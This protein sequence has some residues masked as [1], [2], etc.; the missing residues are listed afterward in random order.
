MIVKNEASN[1]I[2]VLESV[3]RH[4]SGV[5]VCDTGSQDQ[6][7][8][9]VDTFC[10]SHKAIKCRT[11]HHA[12]EDFAH[13]RNLCFQD[14][15][16][17]MS[18]H[19][20]F[21]LVLDADQ[22]LIALNNQSLLEL[23][24]TADAYKLREVSHGYEYSHFRLT[25]VSKNFQYT[26]A[27]HEVLTVKEGST[28]GDLPASFYT[29]HETH[30]RRGIEQ[31]II[32]MEKDLNRNPSNTRTIFH[33]ALAYFNVNITASFRLFTK[34][35]HLGDSP[36][37]E[38]IFWCKY[39]LARG[40]EMTFFRNDE[41]KLNNTKELREIGLIQ[42][43]DVTFLDVQ[44]AF[45]RASSNKP[46]RYEPWARLASLFWVAKKDAEECYRFAYKGITAGPVTRNTL[47]AEATVIPEL[48]HLLCT[49]GASVPRLAQEP[50][51]KL[52]CDQSTFEQK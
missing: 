49:C 40:L 50:Q 14:G 30:H 35:I 45:E 15:K 34:R 24:L 5:V 6:T 11:L 28:V 52:S 12:W 39:S 33:L 27:I 48:H 37:S 9:L 13:N 20:R 3:E 7:L 17:A 1:I 47:F 51:V 16:R 23:P 10:G 42:G 46:Y 8:A 19:C 22:R 2:H 4:V 32:L 44:K 21:W 36:G 18:S 38:E 29:T 43:D 31:D 41:Y 25:D 26:G